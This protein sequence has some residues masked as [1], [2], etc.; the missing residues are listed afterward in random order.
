M[1]NLFEYEPTTGL[2]RWL[3]NKG[4][5]KAGTLCGTPHSKGY[6]TVSVGGKQLMLHRV[7]WEL[8]NGH[9]PDGYQ[10][11]HINGNKR[12]NRIANLRLA[13]TGQNL[14][15]RPVTNRNR[16]GIKGVS[17]YGRKYRAQLSCQGVRY[18]RTYN[19]L[20]AAVAGYEAMAKEHHGEYAN[21]GRAV[22]SCGEEI[23]DRSDCSL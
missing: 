17:K 12:D 7:I 14:A 9:I 20:E 8:V 10:V 5:V 19:T 15:N 4:P 13:M 16:L 22:V 1:H 11:D 21:T 2:V 3:V 6:L 18:C 23:S